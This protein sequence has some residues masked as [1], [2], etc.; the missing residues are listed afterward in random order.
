[1]TEDERS[2]GVDFRGLLEDLRDHDYPATVGD[3]EDAYGD[4]RLGMPDGEEQ[5]GAVLDVYPTDQ[6]FDDAEAV[7]TAV[8]NAVGDDAVGREEY[9]DR[10][11]GGAEDTEES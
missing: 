8:M 3:L 4:R 10:G 6:T 7:E 5:F 11:T 2:H 9:T 1:M